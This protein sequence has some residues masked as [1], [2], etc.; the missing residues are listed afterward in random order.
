MSDTAPAGVLFDLD[1]TLLDTAPDLACA[2][3]RVRA[4]RGLPPL[5]FADIRPHVSHGSYALT[6]LGFDYTATSPEFEATRIAVL[7]AYRDCLADSTRPFDGI[8]ALL[9]AL[10]ARGCRWGIVTN[11][12]G[13]LTT[14]L[15]AALGLTPRTASVVSG[16][17]LPERKPHPAPLLHAA[18]ELALAPERCV[19]VG[20]AQRDVEAGQRAGMPT[21]VALYGYI[22]AD[23]DP[24]SW[25]ASALLDSPAAIADWLAAQAGV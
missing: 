25:G 6:R 10:E 3:N 24:Y 1:G 17:S 2:L 21:L 13:W 12:P 4:D 20:D 18:R 14:P 22:P 5:P 8:D 23:E 16:D 19:Y 11:K 7:D 15:L 9:D